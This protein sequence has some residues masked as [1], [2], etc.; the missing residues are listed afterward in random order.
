MC[1]E[2]QIGQVD[3]NT[4]GEYTIAAPVTGNLVHSTIDW[5]IARPIVAIIK[6][7][8][9][10]QIDDETVERFINGARKIMWGRNI[11]A[12]DII[13][14]PQ[15]LKVTAEL[16][17][18]TCALIERTPVGFPRSPELDVETAL[19]ALFVVTL[20]AAIGVC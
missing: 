14:S 11:M 12:Q 13:D 20:I 7:R 8:L 4:V 2:A 16:V 19:Y 1:V 5:F 9:G 10:T 3:E 18:I 17:T 6:K 15:K